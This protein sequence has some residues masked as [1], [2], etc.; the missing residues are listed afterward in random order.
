MTVARLIAVV[1]AT[2]ILSFGVAWRSLHPQVRYLPEFKAGEQLLDE[3]IA[4]QQRTGR[5]PGRDELP[6]H[7]LELVSFSHEPETTAG[8]RIAFSFSFD[9][10]WVLDP[11]S[12]R[13]FSHRP[14]GYGEPLTG[15]ALSG[16]ERLSEGWAPARR[17]TR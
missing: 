17:R 11:W 4:F 3:V 2:A 10:Y 9:G 8:F 6:R 1:S 15:A 7:L 5:L 12:R 14:A 16:P 13:W